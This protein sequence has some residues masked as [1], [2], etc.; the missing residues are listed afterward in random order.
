MSRPNRESLLFDKIA[1]KEES[2]RVLH[3][4]DETGFLTCSKQILE[5]KGQFQV[6]VASSVE[7]AL[8]K[9][10]KSIY[11]VVVSDYQMPIKDGLQFLRELREKGNNIPFILFT[12]KGREEVAI[13][14]LNLGAN[15]YVNKMGKPET[16]Y[17]EL[18][19][20]INQVVNQ[21]ETKNRLGLERERLQTVTKNMSAGLAV[22]SKDFRILWANDV[23]ENV[24]G[25]N[26]KG[27]NASLL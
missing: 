16:I 1:S 21:N 10:K 20:I 23:L 3:V 6:D 13:Q 17:G 4:D 9:M 27:K 5:L 14:A 12:G 24:F 15:Y 26:Y 2:I 7:E 18:A 8:A 25:D 22:I 11:D 19:H